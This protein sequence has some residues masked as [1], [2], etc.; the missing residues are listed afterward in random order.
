MVTPRRNIHKVAK[1]NAIGFFC[2]S[3]ILI[4]D[5]GN[6]VLRW[7]CQQEHFL[8]PDP[9]LRYWWAGYLKTDELVMCGMC[10]LSSRTT[11]I[12]AKDVRYIANQVEY[13][14]NIIR[15]AIIG[16][17]FLS[18]VLT[19]G[20]YPQMPGTIVTHWNAAGEADGYMPAIRGIMIVPLI[21]IGLAALFA[22]LPRID[23]LR[24]NYEK[25]R[26]YYEGF[27]LLLVLFFFIIQLQVI[28]WNIG[29]QVSPNLTF[30]VLFGILFVYTGFLLEHAEQNWFVGIRTPWTLSS[31][32]VWKK[33]HERG[34]KL[35]KLAGIVCLAGIL[36][37]EDAVGFILVPILAV[38]VYTVLYSY[39][40]FRKES[41]R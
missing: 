40:E 2:Q 25:F 20:A 13:H 33:T 34:G 3:T 28:L 41:Y 7:Y 15:T 5:G 11:N 35:F 38:A 23:P 26:N 22:I 16:I 12:Y 39:V 37:P 6:A 4:A 36:V 1:D 8:V 14:M 17:I 32:T 27:V 10:V 19:F 30:P 21:T 31:E 9:Q 24:K 18:F 29:V